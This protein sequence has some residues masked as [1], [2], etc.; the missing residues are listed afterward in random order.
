MNS[1]LEI[2]V[3]HSKTNTCDETMEY[4]AVCSP[5]CVAPETDLYDQVVSVHSGQIFTRWWL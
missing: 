2:V 4:T 1:K 5:W 3:T